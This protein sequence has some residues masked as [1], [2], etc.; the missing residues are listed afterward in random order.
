L[1]NKQQYAAP[2][3]TKSMFIQE[4]YDKI[5]YK[6]SIKLAYTAKEYKLPPREVELELLLEQVEGNVPIIKVGSKYIFEKTGIEKK[7]NDRITGCT[8]EN[9]EAIQWLL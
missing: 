2:S 5:G 1:R 9:S 4:S 3:T 7:Q 8:L 6:L